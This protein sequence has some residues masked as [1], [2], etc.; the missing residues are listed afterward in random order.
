MAVLFECVAAFGYSACEEG[1]L[2][3]NP[4]D[5][6]NMIDTGESV[7]EVDG[8]GWWL[9]LVKVKSLWM[10]WLAVAHCK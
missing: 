6:V 7:D 8:E 2:S 4:G 9:G 10:S 5:T 3:F 1:G